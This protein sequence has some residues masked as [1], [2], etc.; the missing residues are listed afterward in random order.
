MLNQALRY[1]RV[2]EL[3]AAEPRGG[4]LLE[5]GSGSRGINDLLDERWRVTALDRSFD[6]YGAARTGDSAGLERVVGDVTALPFADRS[7]DAVVALDLLE[8]VPPQ[9]RA[10]ALGEIGRVS[11]RIAIVGCPCGEAALE[12]DRRLAARYRRIRGSAPGWL[13]EH[14]E[15]GFP[16]AGELAGG[17]GAHGDV[18]LLDN[19]SVAAHEAVATLEALPL[20]WTVSAVASRALAGGSAGG[21]PLA[22]SLR[23]RAATLLR[24]GDR[25]PSY[26]TIAVLRRPQR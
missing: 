24:G 16:T 2:T 9:L 3:L 13:T 10:T 7:F 18:T 6:D 12:G 22:S 25:A 4:R 19:E 1:R 21:R 11:D 15:N 14:L 17:L 26:R 23:G 20:L 5:V 8:H